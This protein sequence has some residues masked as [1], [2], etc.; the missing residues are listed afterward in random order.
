MFIIK[1]DGQTAIELSLLIAIVILVLIF[2]IPPLRES[3]EGV[4]SKVII[5]LE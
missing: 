1:E 4:I 5:P 3:V 2:S